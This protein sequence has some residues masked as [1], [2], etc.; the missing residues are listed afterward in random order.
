VNNSSTAQV[1]IEAIDRCF[2]FCWNREKLQYY[3]QANPKIK[4]AF[5]YLRG[6]DIMDK[7][8]NSGSYPG[9]KLPLGGKFHLPSG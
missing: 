2:Y 5:D 3:L 7:V 4:K 8:K 6:K 1:T 9:V